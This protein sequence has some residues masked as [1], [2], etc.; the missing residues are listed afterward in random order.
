MRLEHGFVQQGYR[1]RLA[2]FGQEGWLGGCHLLDR[3]S[4]EKAWLLSREGPN[5]GGQFVVY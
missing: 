1:F 4:V 3:L 5:K 2:V